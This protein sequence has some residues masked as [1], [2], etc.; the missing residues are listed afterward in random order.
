MDRDSRSVDS[1]SVAMPFSQGVPTATTTASSDASGPP[2]A[3]P[4][5]V[6]SQPLN[7]LP[8]SPRRSRSVRIAVEASDLPHTQ[9]SVSRVDLPSLA[10]KLHV[11]IG[12]LSRSL[13]ISNAPEELFQDLDKDYASPQQRTPQRAGTVRMN[14]A[15][16]SSSIG[17]RGVTPASSPSARK[18]SHTLGSSLSGSVR[19]WFSGSAATTSTMT[20]A[21]AAGQPPLPASTSR[22]QVPRPGASPP[23]ASDATSGQSHE[24]GTFGSRIPANVDAVPTLAATTRPS[25]RVRYV[26]ATPV[27][28]SVPVPRGNAELGVLWEMSGGVAV[29]QRVQPG[30]AAAAAGLQEGMRLLSVED[31]PVQTQADLVQ[32]MARAKKERAGTYVSMTLCQGVP[33]QRTVSRDSIVSFGKEVDDDVQSDGSFDT[34]SSRDPFEN[35]EITTPAADVE[36]E[37]HENGAARVINGQADSAYL[38]NGPAGTRPYFAMPDREQRSGRSYPGGSSSIKLHG[39]SPGGHSTGAD[40]GTSGDQPPR[41]HS[42]SQRPSF[43]GSLVRGMSGILG[44]AKMDEEADPLLPSPVTQPKR[45]VYF[46]DDKEEG[47]GNLITSVRH[48]EE[49]D[50]VLLELRFVFPKWVWA[51]LALTL[52]FFVI[53]LPIMLRAHEHGVSVASVLGAQSGVSLAATLVSFLCALP[54]IR[55]S[56]YSYLR[57]DYGWLCVLLAAVGH[58]A[59]SV[60]AMLALVDN[61]KCHADRHCPPVVFEC[62]CPVILVGYFAVTRYIHRRKVG[63]SEPPFFAFELVGMLLSLAGAGILLTRQSAGLRV[64]AILLSTAVSF[65]VSLFVIMGRRIA[66]Q[67]PVPF[68]AFLVQLVSSALV[69]AVLLASKSFEHHDP[70]TA[71]QQHPADMLMPGLAT[72]GMTVCA[73]LI[74]CYLHPYPMAAI[75]SLGLV[76]TAVGARAVAGV[77]WDNAS[78]VAI[79]AVLLSC[80]GTLLATWANVHHRSVVEVEIL[81]EKKLNRR[82]ASGIKGPRRN[83]RKRPSADCVPIENGDTPQN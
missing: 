82:K 42:A 38:V 32:C 12:T 7:G 26:P 14:T 19:E 54:W 24:S 33:Q 34:A 41:Y 73:L 47:N 61:S 9:G 48:Y 62:L 8:A 70:F 1:F 81:Q 3:S 11:P 80:V 71:F 13:S 16:R 15:E 25:V 64:N 78:N 22:R 57:V 52:A 21:G 68:T 29:A 69:F 5:S 60:T 75:F 10:R 56:N 35:L 53:P 83:R 36:V 27:V 20:A 39:T 65:S 63:Q 18:V 79:P 37:V 4:A 55:H 67:L 77:K 6:F 50:T 58:A 17:I 51:V 72:A 2:R 74:L 30:S 31:T 46:A 66:S 28:L 49:I 23:V 76:L 40:S 45:H 43:F 44:F 59:L